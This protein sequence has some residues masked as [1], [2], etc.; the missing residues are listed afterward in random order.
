MRL[1]A[2]DAKELDRGEVAFDFADEIH[3]L[4]VLHVPHGAPHSSRGA[5]TRLTPKLGTSA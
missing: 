3:L 5:H 1:A 4:C 2:L